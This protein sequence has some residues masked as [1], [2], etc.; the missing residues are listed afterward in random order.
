[1]AL[2]AVNDWKLWLTDLGLENDKQ[3]IFSMEE[4]AKK[5]HNEY[6]VNAAKS[7]TQQQHEDFSV[8]AARKSTYR[9]HIQQN[10]NSSSLPYNKDGLCTGCGKP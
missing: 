7:S 5:Q 9:K 1:M 2:R 6:H 8:N 10:K 4:A 3:D